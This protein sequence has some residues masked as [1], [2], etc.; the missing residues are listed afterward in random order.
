VHPGHGQRRGL[1]DC[2][3]ARGGVRT[4]HQRDLARAWRCDIGGETALA[5]DEASILAYT[6]IARHEAER[7]RA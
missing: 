2:E 7:S 3:N 1:V 5:G 6:A 4:C